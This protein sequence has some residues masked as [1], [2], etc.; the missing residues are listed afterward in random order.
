MNT[1]AIPTGFKKL[2]ENL[3]GGL[4]EGLYVVGAVSSLGK[5]TLVMQIADQIAQGEQDVLIFS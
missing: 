3:G 5:T 2:D 1:P 4:F